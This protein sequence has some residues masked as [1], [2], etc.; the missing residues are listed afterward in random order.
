MEIS[1]TL[2][3]KS[4]G[5]PSQHAQL[6]ACVRDRAETAAEHGALFAFEPHIGGLVNRPERALHLLADVAHSALRVHFDYSH[7]ELLDIPLEEAMDRLLGRTAGV[8]VKD[9]AGRYPDFR[10]LLP[11]E[12][13]LDY[14]AIFVSWRRG[15]TTVQ[16]R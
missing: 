14:D 15:D 8:H 6:A 5:W 16:S 11:G 3:G 10:F 13:T 7:F 9:V 4:E 12:G 2:G 1:S